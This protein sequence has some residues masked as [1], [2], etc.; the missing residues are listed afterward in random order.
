M[1]LNKFKKSIFLSCEERN[2]LLFL[3]R[4]NYRWY[5]KRAFL[6]RNNKVLQF[7]F[8]DYSFLVFYDNF[9]M[10]TFYFLFDYSI[11]SKDSLGLYCNE[12]FTNID[13]TSFGKNVIPPPMSNYSVNS[14]VRECLYWRKNEVERKLN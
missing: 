5:V 7:Y 14:G 2:Y 9:E 6:T 1:K 8:V 11:A 3:H 4:S 13:I 12:D 10:E